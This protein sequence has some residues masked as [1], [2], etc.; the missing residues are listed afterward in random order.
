MSSAKKA[1]AS[2][3][4]LDIPGVS[5][6]T[7]DLKTEMPY[8]SKRNYV[9]FNDASIKVAKVNT[10]HFKLFLNDCS[11]IFIVLKLA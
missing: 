7:A 8:T 2:P 1:F 3:C 10:M 9:A 5:Y 6:D 4:C 11:L